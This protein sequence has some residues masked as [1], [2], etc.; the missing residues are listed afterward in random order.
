M[1]P[2]HVMFAVYLTMLVC[3]AALAARLRRLSSQQ[4]DSNNAHAEALEAYRVAITEMDAR[5]QNM[6]HGQVADAYPDL[7]TVPVS[8]DDMCYLREEAEAM[9]ND[10]PPTRHG[11]VWRSASGGGE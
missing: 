5:L 4:I 2:H 8:L 6:E 3:I 9:H 7:R 11:V 1:S 10:A